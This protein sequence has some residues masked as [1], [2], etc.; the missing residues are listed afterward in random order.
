M[1]SGGGRI[2]RPPPFFCLLVELHDSFRFG[3]S[4]ECFDP[5]LGFGHYPLD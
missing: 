1:K 3:I 4:R 2:L 5:D